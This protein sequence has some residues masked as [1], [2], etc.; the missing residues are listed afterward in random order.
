M[1]LSRR[2]LLVASS[3]ALLAGCSEQNTDTDN[4]SPADDDAT[5]SMTPADSPEMSSDPAPIKD[6]LAT[7]LDLLPTQV[8]GSPLNAVQI[9]DLSAGLPVPGLRGLVGQPSEQLG[10]SEDQINWRALAFA[11]V[12]TFGIVRITTGSFAADAVSLPDT[13]G[14][15]VEDG[16]VIRATKNGEPWQAAVEAARK[17]RADP[18]A[19]YLPSVRSIIPSVQAS[20]LISLVR[21]VGDQSLIAVPNTDQFDSVKALAWGQRFITLQQQEHQFAVRVADDENPSEVGRSVIKPAAQ[22]NILNLDVQ[23]GDIDY[24]TTDQTV[25]GM[26][27]GPVLSSLQPDNS[28]DGRFLLRAAEMTASSQ[29]ST[30]LEYTGEEPV[31]PD[32]LNVVVDGQSRDPPWAG[33][34]DPIS[35]GE[36]F[37]LDVRPLRSVR[38]LWIDPQYDN[39][40]QPM[41]IGVTSGESV[42]EHNYMY[43]GTGKLTI[44]YTGDRDIDADQVAIGD[45]RSSVSN[46]TQLNTVIGERLRPGESFTL[47]NVAPDT[48]IAVLFQSRTD[49][50][51]RLR[52]RVYSLTTPVPGMFDFALADADE[53]VTITYQ[54]RDRPANQ[55]QIQLNSSSTPTQFSDQYTMLTAGDSIEIAATVGDQV[56]INW[57]DDDNSV[58]AA[59]Y[60]VQPAATFDVSH[61]T[62]TGELAVT[63]TDGDQIDA[64]ALRL[65][66]APQEIGFQ[67]SAWS[68][69]ETVTPGDTT[70]VTID[71]AVEPVGVAVLYNDTDTILAEIEL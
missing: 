58:T 20:Q 22:E 24:E 31:A 50:Q 7:V 23:A 18:D 39:V 64:S 12:E 34:A 45:Q 16:L 68:E 11:D 38:V 69:Y 33:R 15:Y 59:Q 21:G 67:Q 19:G 46:T 51:I 65:F 6:G 13:P 32:R 17:I 26:I 1:D 44:R 56:V 27:A 28:P 61:D 30:V 42:F 43:N 5:N 48:P 52:D 41:G 35:P 60:A 3:A 53:V 14:T 66:V 40:E 2:R 63:L 10:V 70:T 37:E 54:G 71:P 8:D 29:R 47:E 9:F 57:T 55:Y 62:D 4:R 36:S 25:T 49:G